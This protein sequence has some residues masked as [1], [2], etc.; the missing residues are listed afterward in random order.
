MLKI[1]SCDAEGL[2]DLEAQV[3]DLQ[4]LAQAVRCQNGPANFVVVG[5]RAVV[6]MEIAEV[7]ITPNGPQISA[8]TRAEW[9]EK[10]TKHR[11]AQAAR[12]K[13]SSRP[14]SDD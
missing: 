12:A 1:L 3:N 11:E 6:V 8:L 9:D 7:K 2:V 13:F 5:D 10:V 4:E 14:P